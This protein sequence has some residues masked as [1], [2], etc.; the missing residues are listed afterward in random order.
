MLT[1]HPDL[2]RNLKMDT[3]YFER[4]FNYENTYLVLG[5]FFESEEWEPFRKVNQLT[6]EGLKFV[7]ELLA[8]KPE[9][10]FA[11]Y[12]RRHHK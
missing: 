3:S 7:E 1:H 11:N 4:K 9:E 5:K 6:A 8:D 12:F 10:T 2:T